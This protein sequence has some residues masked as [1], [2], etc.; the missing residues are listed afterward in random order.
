[1]S[2]GLFCPVFTDWLSSLSLAVKETEKKQLILLILIKGIKN[3]SPI[4]N[5][6]YNNGFRTWSIL[7]LYLQMN[8]RLYFIKKYTGFLYELL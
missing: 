1:M 6:I 3:I 7:V 5:S 4:I 8:D 2:I